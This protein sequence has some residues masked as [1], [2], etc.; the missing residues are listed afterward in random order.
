MMST[1]KLMYLRGEVDPVVFI[2]KL[3][4]AKSYAMLYRIDY[5]YEENPEGIRKPNN[6]FLVLYIY[7]DLITPLLPTLFN[8][9]RF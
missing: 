1:K 5:G 9:Y 2:K 6:H 4:K 7:I 3:F 8:C